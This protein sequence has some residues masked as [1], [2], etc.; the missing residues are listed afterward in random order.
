M[1]K[2]LSLLGTIASLRQTDL[3]FDAHSSWIFARHDHRLNFSAFIS[4]NFLAFQRLSETSESLSPSSSHYTPAPDLP[5]L[6]LL[7]LGLIFPGFD[8]SFYPPFCSTL[9]V[10]LRSPRHFLNRFFSSLSLP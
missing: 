3:L 6:I 1:F 8:N 2:K 4:H 9:V 7:L 5:R 10:V